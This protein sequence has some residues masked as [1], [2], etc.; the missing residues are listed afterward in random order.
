M[1]PEW[2]NA[3]DGSIHALPEFSK[4]GNGTKIPITLEGLESGYVVFRKN[5]KKATTKTNFPKSKR[6][7]EIHTAW[8]VMF[9]DPFGEE[10]KRKFTSLENWSKSDDI[11]L[12]CFPNF[13]R[14]IFQLLDYQLLAIV[15]LVNL[16]ASL[17]I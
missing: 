5:A 1:Q 15:K 7:I 2:W 10:F 11:K 3:I 13:F 16:G 9:T 4:N 17:Y 14:P 8:N 12:T 6:I